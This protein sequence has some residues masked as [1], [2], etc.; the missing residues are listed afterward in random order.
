MADP[1]I[2][3]SAFE[4]GLFVSCKGGNSGLQPD[5]PAALT[6]STLTNTHVYISLR[7]Q[8]S[9]RISICLL[10]DTYVYLCGGMQRNTP[11]SH[12]CKPTRIHPAHLPALVICL[13]VAAQLHD[14]GPCLDVAVYPSGGWP[15][16]VPDTQQQVPSWLHRRRT[17]MRSRG[18]GSRAARSSCALFNGDGDR[19][20]RGS[21]RELGCRGVSRLGGG[22]GN[23]CQSRDWGPH[24]CATGLL[25]VDT[26]SIFM[27]PGRG[28]DV[29]AA[30]QCTCVRQ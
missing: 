7:A 25:R 19:T 16:E 20:L 23:A 9:S 14:D 17:S 10:A 1:P 22:D 12:K 27:R 2:P 8:P 4:A 15:A 29:G 5:I 24:N 28:D 13:S 26:S 6:R 11:S 30:I 18:L 3:V 21:S